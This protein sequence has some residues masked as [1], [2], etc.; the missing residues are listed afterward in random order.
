MEQANIKVESVINHNG[1]RHDVV[2]LRTLVVE[3][4]PSKFMPW[5]KVN[6]P[7]KGRAGKGAC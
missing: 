5:M 4:P 1:V 7:R 3:P 6:V 2:P